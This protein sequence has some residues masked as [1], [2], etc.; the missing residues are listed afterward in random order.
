MNYEMDISVDIS[1]IKDTVMYISL[2]LCK[3]GV[4]ECLQVVS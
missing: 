1:E 2:T 3:H 4:S